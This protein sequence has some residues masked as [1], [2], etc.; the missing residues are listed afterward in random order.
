M[1]IRDSRKTAPGKMI[2]VQEIKT[3]PDD[4]TGWSVTSALRFSR[5]RSM[6]FA[7]NR[8]HNSISCFRVDSHNGT[9]LR[10]SVV[11][12]PGSF[13]R[14]FN[15]TPDGRFLLVGLQHDDRLLAYEIDYQ[16]GTLYPTGKECNV[17][18]PCCIIFWRDYE[19][20]NHDEPK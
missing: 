3:L 5:D 10:T 16:N 17:P 18:S 12:L 14:D 19:K 4:Y 7:S 8:G 9:L 11:S 13:P 1:C 15:L 20:V 2:Q 6:L